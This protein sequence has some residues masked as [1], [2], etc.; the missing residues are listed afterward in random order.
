MSARR[1]LG[2]C[3][4]ACAALLA[5]CASAPTPAPRTAASGSESGYPGQCA[6]VELRAKDFPSPGRGVSPDNRGTGSI[7][8][9]ATYR[10]GGKD[11]QRRVGYAFR[12][13][14]ERVDEL[15][16]HLQQQPYI[17]CEGESRDTDTNLP[18]P[19]V[20]SFEGQQGRR[21]PIAP[22]AAGPSLAAPP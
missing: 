13:Q 12:V 17:A 1:T 10:P 20:P 18:G 4:R 7:E 19:R 14:Q 5:A 6:F 8:L 15:R 11:D 21:V 16:A 22:P 3:A 2:R 9:V